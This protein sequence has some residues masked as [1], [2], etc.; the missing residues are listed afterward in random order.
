MFAL[1]LFTAAM[2]GLGPTPVT[3]VRTLGDVVEIRPQMMD[4]SGAR[5][6][7]VRDARDAGTEIVGQLNADGEVEWAPT[8]ANQRG[9]LGGDDAPALIY[10]RAFD[11]V[12]AIDPFEP[13]PQNGNLD[14]IDQP[15]TL[16]TQRQ[17]FNGSSLETDRTLFDRRRLERTEQL[18][19][20]LERARRAWL[21]ANGYAGVR[22]LTNPNAEQADTATKTPEPAGWFRKP[23][24]MPRGKSREAVQADPIAPDRAHAIAASLLEDGQAR[25]SLPPGT[26]GDVAERV[27]ARQADDERGE[28]VAANDPR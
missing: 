23:A 19:T 15:I 21:R 10:V 6:D 2:L 16:V 4:A 24:E 26:R 22:T 28:E 3:H 11:G 14:G 7:A 18:F 17:L 25:I 12:F 27:A 20:E 1:S 8:P 5:R 13:L 9:L